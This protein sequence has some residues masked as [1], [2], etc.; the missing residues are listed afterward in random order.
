VENLV[1]SSDDRHCCI[2]IIHISILKK[3]IKITP[4]HFRFLREAFE[5]KIGS[6]FQDQRKEGIKEKLSKIR[7]YHL[8]VF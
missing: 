2:H 1:Y 8:N 3:R 6:A 4:L 7:G 5:D